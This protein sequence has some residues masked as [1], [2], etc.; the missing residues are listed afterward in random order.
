MKI[1]IIIQARCDSA[2]FPEKVLQK[3]EGHSMLWHVIQ[4]CIATNF[5]V[6]VSTTNRKIDDPIIDIALSCNVNYFR[7]S[8]NDVLDRFYQTA[9]QFNLDGIIRITADCPLI[10]PNESKKVGL[11]LKTKQ[12]DYVGLN[13]KKYPDGLDTE[14]FTFQTLENIWKNAKLKSER[15]HVTPYLKK[16]K[17]NFK[18]QIIEPKSDL[19]KFRFTVD[20]PDD[21]E[22]VRK[23]YSEL[24]KKDIFYL[25]DILD[26]L[27]NHPET[28]AINSSHKRNQGYIKS[29]L[30]DSTFI[31]D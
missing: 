3:I 21:L 31:S 30:K 20:H 22:F 17:K 16:N 2:R 29:L 28:L 8:V 6:I 11:K 12:F 4:R 5:P 14:G 13:G 18:I 15:E 19:S 26:F 10:D 1:G 27:K 7:G 25:H 23:I 9:K 24:Y